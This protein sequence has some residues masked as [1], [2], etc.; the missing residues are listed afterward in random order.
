RSIVDRVGF[1]V[2]HGPQRTFKIIAN[3][4]RNLLE[5]DITFRCLLHTGGA[6]GIP[7]KHRSPLAKRWMVNREPSMGA[8]HGPRTNRYRIIA[9]APAN[10]LNLFYHPLASNSIFQPRHR[11]RVNPDVAGEF[12][13]VSEFSPSGFFRLLGHKMFALQHLCGARAEVPAHSIKGSRC[14]ACNSRSSIEH[15][16]GSV[17]WQALAFNHAD[18]AHLRP[19]SG[20]PSIH[21]FD[22]SALSRL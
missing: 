12:G 1:S 13:I 2:E 6:I 17:I 21:V 7:L 9:G 19:Q 8:V 18:V 16:T 5:N 20:A 3:E 11:E 22:N 4:N 14:V 15:H 10:I